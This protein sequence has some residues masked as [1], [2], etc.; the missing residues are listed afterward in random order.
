MGRYT[1]APQLASM[2]KAAAEQQAAKGGFTIAYGEPRY[3]ETAAKDV[4]LSQDPPV[5][6]RIVKGGAIT[7]VLSL[8]AERYTVPDVVGMTLDLATSELE[9]AKLVVTKGPDRYDDNLPKGVVIGVDPKVGT[10]LKPGDKVTVVVSKGKAPLSVPRVIGKNVN[11][12]RNE[13]VALGLTPLVGYAKSDEPRDTVIDQNPKDGAGVEKG[14]KVELSVSEGPP[15]VLVPPVVGLPCQ[16]AVAQL[17]GMNLRATPQ[18]NPN[19]TVA[20]QNPGPNTPV[21]PQT[22]V[23]LVCL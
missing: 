10:E 7:L 5:G 2:T 11:D 18:F 14:A 12:A 16:Q 23:V 9:K 4:V 20:Q 3:D 8:G 17:Q 21:P 19:G 13:L 6:G 15:Q 1:V 22:E